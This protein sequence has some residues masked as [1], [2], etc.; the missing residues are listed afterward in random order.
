MPP[1]LPPYSKPQS[2]VDVGTIVSSLVDFA[3]D[4]DD[5]MYVMSPLYSPCLVT[6]S[7]GLLNE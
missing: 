2:I 6:L 3:L 4:E 1:W 5:G 7:E